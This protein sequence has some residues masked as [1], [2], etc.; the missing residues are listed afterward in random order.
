MAYD[1]VRKRVVMV[2]EA[3]DTTVEPRS[4]TWEFDGVRWER[5]SF[6]GEGVPPV[7]RLSAM[8]YDERRHRMVMFGGTN[9]LST[10]N[11]RGDTWEYDGSHWTQVSV[12]G[13]SARYG[14]SMCYDSARGRV[15]LVGGFAGLGSGYVSDTW[16]FNGAAWTKV[17]DT[18]ALSGVSVSGQALEFDRSRG[19]PVLVQPLQTGT[20]VAELKDGAWT[21]RDGLGSG[22]DSADSPAIAF[23]SKRGAIMTFGGQGDWGIATD[24]RRLDG[25]GWT[26][27]PALRPSARAAASMAY[28]SARD[29]VVMF[30]G[31]QVLDGFSP[32]ARRLGDTWQFDGFT[33]TQRVIAGAVPTARSWHA[34]VYD[35]SRASVVMFGGLDESAKALSDLWEFDG[36]VCQKRTIS[37]PAPAGRR[38][39]VMVYDPDRHRVILFG[40]TSASGAVLG[41]HWEFD[42]NTWQQI[43]VARPPA[44]TR[45]SIAYD[46]DRK[47]VVL[48]GGFDGFNALQDTWEYD[49][50]SWTRHAIG[51]FAPIGCEGAVMGYDPVRHKVVLHSGGVSSGGEPTAFRLTWEYDGV[52]WTDVTPTV[53]STPEP[54]AYSSMVFDSARGRFVMFGGLMGGFSSWTESLETWVF[55]TSPVAIRRDPESR[56]VGLGARTEL[57]VLAQGAGPLTYRWR[58]SGVELS[59]GGGIAGSGTNVLVIQAATAGD[60]GGYDCVVTDACGLTATSGSALVTLCSRSDCPADFDDSG[61]TADATDIDAFFMA[62]LAGEPCADVDASGGTPDSMD[63]EAFFAAWL[64]GC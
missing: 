55:S 54:H 47:R 18:L 6:D 60:A 27:L 40:G 62:W 15:V 8:V 29:V 26:T 39:H 45:A 52:S 25:S 50:T 1:P 48:W 23:Y 53:G 46:S 16:E 63:V 5:R 58:R 37:G 24:L 38:S 34:M 13:P 30:G 35:A 12:S 14:H 4:Q 31:R 11:R 7:R 33:W 42:G 51:G 9:D 57:A 56:T 21:I 43:S 64:V 20:V 22:P 10:P 3:Q 36:S 17:S 44:R 41:D 2:L 59:D 49:G 61:G 28:D 19:V 32:D